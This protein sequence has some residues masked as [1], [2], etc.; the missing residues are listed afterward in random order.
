MSYRWTVPVV[1]LLAFGACSTEAPRGD[2]AHGAHGAG[3]SP[4]LYD[5]LGNYSYRITTA[6]PQAQRWFDQGLRL[7]YAF[8]H[9]EAQRAFREAA[10]LDPGCAM[11][12][13]GIAMTE[14]GNYN[15]PTDTER[16]G[17][18]LDAIKV[19]QERSARAT[20]HERAMIDAVVKRH[21][22]DPAAK[23]RSLKAQV[24]WH[25]ASRCGLARL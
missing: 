6:S 23:R 2:M 24:A 25:I 17:R 15:D 21:S 22:A 16:E 1:L 4:V 18:A 13:W 20:P 10:R 9:N 8:N 14:G 19:A 11:C 5:S 3:G 7:V 12:F